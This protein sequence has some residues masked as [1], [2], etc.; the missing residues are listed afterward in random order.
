MKFLIGIFWNSGEA[1]LRAAFRLCI[2]LTTYIGL[3]IGLESLIGIIINPIEFNS[4]APLWLFLVFAIVILVPG[5]MSVY[6]VG[7]FLDRR[8]FKEFGLHLNKQWWLDLIFGMVLGI[9]MISMIFVIEILFG[10]IKIEEI[11]FL[12]NTNQLFIF[13]IS[14]FLVIFLCVAISEELVTRGYILKNLAE[15]LNIKFISPK[16]AIVL[17]WILASAIFGLFHLDNNN[18]TL[19]STLNISIGGIF[20][21]IGF[22]FTGKLAMPIG[23]HITWNFFMASVFGFPVSGFTLPSEV[24]SIFKISQSGPEI[25]TGGAFGPEGGLLCSFSILFGVI[26]T[27]TWLRLNRRLDHGLI[28][29]PLAKF[30]K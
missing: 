28:H 11:L 27:V 20:F 12:L 25:W 4:K 19:L 26:I 23:L 21:G 7:R 13:P 17:G 6:P 10:W 29:L 3:G 22:V 24:V 18:A 1:R 5:L 16:V 2:L 14:I 8:S 9:L 30:R 15:G